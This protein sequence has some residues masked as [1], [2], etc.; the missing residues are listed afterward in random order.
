MSDS[1][2][3][4]P[5][6]PSMPTPCSND[7][8]GD[9]AC[10]DEEGFTTWTWWVADQQRCATTYHPPNHQ[11]PLPLLISNDCYS[12][13]GLGQCRPGSEMV[14]AANRF[15]F[16]G[17]CTTAADGNWTFGNDGVINDSNPLPCT[18]EDSKDITY[19]DGVFSIVDAFAESG[20]VDDARV[21][22]WGFSQNAMFTAYMS[23]CYPNRIN[24]FWQ[25]GSG[26]FVS[27][28][29][30]PLPQMEG[31]CRKSD[32]R[33]FGSS[34]VDQAP[35]DACEYFPIYPLQTT[36]PQKGCIMMYADDFLSDTA[37]PMA[38]IMAEQG[39]QA[40]L[41]QFPDIGRGHSN[42]LIHWD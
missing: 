19:M 41:L 16:A 4:D 17:L 18:A 12:S 2:D 9:C 11:G 20:E 3:I 7:N 21:F 6:R 36:P 24:T 30:D 5:S 22:A 31:V 34:C 37:A 29:T 27:G 14:E 32:F 42:S 8:R 15:G 10:S 40:T 33:E 39:H 35:C 26:L 25:G 13:N 38:R 23:F 28:E 1:G